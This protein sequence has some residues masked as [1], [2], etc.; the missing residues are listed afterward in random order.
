MTATTFGPYAI[1][2][3]VADGASVTVWRARHIELGRLVAIKAL[4]VRLCADADAVAQLRSEA[5]RLTELDDPHIVA[6]YDFVD[7]AE[8]PYLVTEWVPGRTLRELFAELGPLRPEQ[9]LGVLRGALQGL[10]YA[11][12]RGLVHGDVSLSNLIVDASGTTKLI[13]FGL[14]APTGSPG[15]SGTPAYLSPEAASGDRLTPASDVYSAGAVL[16]QLLSGAPP[17]AGTDVLATIRAHRE[18]PAPALRDHGPELADLLDRALR[19]QPSE[20]P[21]D[22]AAFLAELEE[23]AR[24]RYGTAWLSAA[25]VAGLAGMGV[26]GGTAAMVAGVGATGSAATGAAG[27]ETVSAMATATAETGGG[28]A[29]GVVQTGRRVGRIRHAFGA[30]PVIAGGAAV[31]VVAAAVTTA[32]ITT[33]GKSKPPPPPEAV[34]LAS[35]PLGAFGATGAITSTTDSKLKAGKLGTFPWTITEKCTATACAAVVKAPGSTFRFR[36][37]GDAFTSSTLEQSRVTCVLPSGKKVPGA[38]ALQHHSVVWTL[39][40]T[41]RA[42]ATP[43]GPGRALDLSGTALE[44]T[45]YSDLTGNCKDNVGKKV[46]QY[47]YTIHRK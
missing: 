45:T 40:V 29:A 21:A 38:T 9:S 5:R 13:D 1:E 44:T 20:R 10:A 19:K 2:E 47:S 33:A 34:L 22:A 4:S 3:L 27:T 14:A 37:A 6:I 18:E 12:H 42:P 24:A 32:V 7:E 23:A 15:V 35:S 28:Q 43:D 36:Y 25:S 8:R 39:R 41:H 26:A 31:V 46:T 17:F 16:Y 30:H 11:H